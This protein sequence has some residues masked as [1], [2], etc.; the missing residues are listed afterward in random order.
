MLRDTSQA[1]LAH[2]S[3]NMRKQARTRRAFSVSHEGTY[4]TTAYLR[5]HGGVGALDNSVFERS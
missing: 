2:V 4:R 3:T 5:V 1:S